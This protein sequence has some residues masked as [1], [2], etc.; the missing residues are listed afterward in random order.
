MVSIRHYNMVDETYIVNEIKESA[1]F[2]SLD[3]KRDLERTWNSA[4]AKQKAS[5]GEEQDIVMDYVLPDY[6]SHKKGYMRTHDPSL[7]AKLTKLGVMKAPPETIEDFMTLGNE[8]FI[9]P[10]L[11]F[12]PR[13]VGLRQPGIPE[14][15]L[16]SLSVVPTGLWPGMLANI[17]VV[18]GNAMMEGFTQRL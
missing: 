12:N 10:E 13:D 3:F 14:M 2:V 11:L 18:G 9:V 4:S 15:V 7:N 6:N 16:Q 17:L 8:R 1:C 5:G